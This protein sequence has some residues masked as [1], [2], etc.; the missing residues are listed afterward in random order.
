MPS[1]ALSPLLSDLNEVSLTLR[2]LMEILPP[3]DPQFL[4]HLEN[5]L[6]YRLQDHSAAEWVNTYLKPYEVP[7]IV[8]FDILANRF[9]LVLESQRMVQEWLLMQSKGHRRI[10]IMDIG[11]GRGLQISRLLYALNDWQM[12][13]EVTVIGV[14][15]NE[16]A[17]AVTTSLMES[18]KQR[19]NFALHFHPVAG[20]VEKL[21]FEAIRQLIPDSADFLMVNASLTLHHI[22]SGK[23]RNDLFRKLKKFHPDLITLIEPNASTFTDELEKRLCQACEHFYALYSYTN[24]LPLTEE[25]KRSLKTFFSNDFFDPIALPNEA[26]FEKLET[27]PQWIA[28]AQKGGFQPLKASPVLAGITPIPNIS[29]EE[30]A[31][32]YI[33][34]KYGPV[35]LLSVIALA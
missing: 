28:R 4:E 12:P 34:F 6:N 27:G 31:P 2:K 15:L 17:L 22:Q 25:E 9:P 13:L 3:P 8:L 30:S 1:A 14:E 24:T 35:N 21:D 16:E 10:C 23:L 20:A 11:I 26:R 33:N 7:Q 32:G 5:G 18:I 19:V 29:I